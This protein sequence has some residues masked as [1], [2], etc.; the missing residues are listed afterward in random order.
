MN[1]I[2]VCGNSKSILKRAYEIDRSAVYGLNNKLVC[3]R[4]GCNKLEI[5]G[6]IIDPIFNKKIY[7]GGFALAG[8]YPDY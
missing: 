8:L 1:K 7:A 4:I 6:G 5:N 3:A 2:T